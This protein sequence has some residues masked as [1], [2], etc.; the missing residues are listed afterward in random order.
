MIFNI[1]SAEALVFFCVFI[2]VW[3]LARTTCGRWQARGL[4][5]AFVKSPSAPA[6]IFHKFLLK[7]FKNP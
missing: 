7:F 3:G 2:V 6:A 4:A 1:A 5:G